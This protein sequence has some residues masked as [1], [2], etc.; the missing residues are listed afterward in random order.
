MRPLI[1]AFLIALAVI[2][3]SMPRAHAAEIPQNMRHDLDLLPVTETQLVCLALNVY[4]E[5]RSEPYEGRLAVAQVVLNRVKDR[6]FPDNICDVVQENRLGNRRHTCQFSWHCDGASDTPRNQSAWR[7]SIQ[8][9]KVA[10]R[11]VRD[12][13]NGALWYHARYVQPSWA[14]GLAQT[15][16]VGTHLFYVD[17]NP[18][19]VAVASR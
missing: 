7:R 2:V 5:A 4:H 17:I 3:L 10:L 12:R 1:A 19:D 15:T 14:L 9:A 13:T 18:D 11:G 8:I 16:T 6:R